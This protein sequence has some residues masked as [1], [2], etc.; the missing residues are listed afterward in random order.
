MIPRTTTGS[1]LTAMAAALLLTACAGAS[2]DRP[3]EAHGQS[4]VQVE[5]TNNNWLD[6]TVYAV[7]GSMRVRLGTVTTGERER[8][9]LPRSVNVAAGELS[10]L[11]DPIGSGQKYQSQPLIVEP[12]ARV[13]WSLENQLA[14][15]SFSVQSMR[16]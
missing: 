10:L 12:G 16:R 11:A 3:S 7:R 9:K 6:M 1:T 14:L 13:T 4:P 15:S 5:V 2:Y 8:F